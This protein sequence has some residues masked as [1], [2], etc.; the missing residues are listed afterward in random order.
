M[1]PPASNFP[2]SNSRILPLPSPLMSGNI[3][4]YSSTTLSGITTPQQYHSTGSDHS[5]HTPPNFYFQHSNTADGYFP[6]SSGDS[7]RPNRSDSKPSLHSIS[8]ILSSATSIDIPS[9]SSSTS[10]QTLYYPSPA[11]CYWGSTP[12]GTTATTP[13]S[14]IGSS[15]SAYGAGPN[16][17]SGEVNSYSPRDYAG[18]KE[19]DG[20]KRKIRRFVLQPQLLVSSWY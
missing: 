8:S 2:L 6:T 12:S 5:S 18:L 19:E 17:Y 7:R 1:S 15:L 4:H 16:D 3:S 11:N 14:S 10:S 20:G 13:R 9:D